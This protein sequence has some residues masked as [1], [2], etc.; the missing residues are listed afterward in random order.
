VSSA[1]GAQP[2]QQAPGARSRAAAWA[3]R[4]W[5]LLARVVRAAVAAWRRIPRAGRACALIAF[6]NVAIWTVLIPPFMVPDE[7]TNFAY[8]QYIA[9][10]GNAPPQNPA[11]PQQFSPQ[12]GAAIYFT[13]F[14]SV[15]G[16][17][18][19]RGVFTSLEQQTMR[20]GLSSPGNKATLGPGGASNT[21]NQPPLY[22]AL[23][24][25]PYWLSPSNNILTRLEF[26]RLLS[27]L[28]A[29]GTVL[30]IFLFL[31]E[32]LPGTP[33]TWTVGAL[34]VAFQPMF[35]FIGAGVNGDNL[36]FLASAA[37]FFMLARAWKRGLT[38]RRAIAIGAVLAVG[39]LAKLTFLTL[40]PGALLA[41]LWL[42]W[43]DRPAGRRTAL[44]KLGAGAAVAGVPVG[45]YLLLNAAVWGRSTLAGGLNS[46]TSGG[47]PIT[48]GQGWHAYADWMWQ[49]FLPRLPFMNHTYFPGQYPLWTVWLHGAIGQFGW[50]DYKFPAWVY[51]DMRWVVYV[52]AGLAV[53]GVWRLRTRIR[54]LAGLFA[55]FT[56]MA[57]GLM[58]VIAY[59][60]AQAYFTAQPFFAQARYLFPLLALYALGI[61]LATKAL[62]R[63]WGPVLGA[64]LVALALAHNL[65]AETLTISRYYG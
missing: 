20:A 50:L 58:T 35:A 11:A 57:V 44:V 23:E 38:R 47:G 18:L 16:N 30:A 27:A 43:R 51:A 64:L 36:L 55:C 37:T 5:A 19:N 8:A 53:I 9:E 32:L 7:T 45:V 28:M 56:V 39:M 31:R 48:I 12:E 62:P 42:A 33:W 59:E 21:T 6:V 29:A 52:L 34:M 22:Y 63:R 4:L 40:V 24:A 46:V 25:I 41:L 2:R 10:T 15:F 26:M 17:T 14:G 1:A 54:P 49:L 61:V 3:A 65:F 60:S 13:D